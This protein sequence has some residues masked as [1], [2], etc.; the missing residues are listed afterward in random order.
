MS[1][2]RTAGKTRTLDTP[3]QIQLVVEDAMKLTKAIDE[4]FPLLCIDC[5]IALRDRVNIHFGIEK[6]VKQEERL[7]REGN[8]Q[9]TK[10]FEQ[11]YND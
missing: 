3:P 8:R 5:K 10:E 2:I 7:T 1:T 6:M 4:V 11:F 9:E